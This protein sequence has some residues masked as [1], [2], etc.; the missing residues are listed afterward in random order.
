MTAK[1]SFIAR[2]RHPCGDDFMPE[3]FLK[4][5]PEY[6]WQPLLLH[7]VVAGCGMIIIPAP[8]SEDNTPRVAV[9]IASQASRRV[10]FHFG[11]FS[12]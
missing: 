8:A 7:D 5:H 3:S 11:S 10:L 2:R 4:A 1:M 6:R 9:L 12:G